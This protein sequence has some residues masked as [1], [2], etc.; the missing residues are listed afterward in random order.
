MFAQELIE[1]LLEQMEVQGELAGSQSIARDATAKAS[2]APANTTPYKIKIIGARHLSYQ[3]FHCPD[4]YCVMTLGGQVVG[5]TNIVPNNCHP[6]W[7]CDYTVHLPDRLNTNTK[8][9]LQFNV[10]HDNNLGN[11]ISVGR[12]A[13]FLRDDNLQNFLTHNA[14][15]SMRPQGSLLIRI[16]REGEL[17]DTAWYVQRTQEVLRF[18]LEDIIHAFSSKVTSYNSF[19]HH[20][21]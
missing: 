15:L 7:Y 2:A 9:F 16:R 5:A 21:R 11:E 17:E 19:M 12:A 14:T 13:V 10:Y 3:N 6:F 18:T 20:Y 8:A 4:A 1:K